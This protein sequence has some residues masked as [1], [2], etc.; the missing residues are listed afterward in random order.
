[1]CTCKQNFTES[2]VQF[3]RED[4][5][6]VVGRLNGIIGPKDA[7]VA[8]S[9][10]KLTGKYFNRISVSDLLLLFV[11]DKNLYMYTII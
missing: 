1:M 6:G 8:T 9:F 5:N 3:I 4:H 2:I 11:S 10:S 7:E